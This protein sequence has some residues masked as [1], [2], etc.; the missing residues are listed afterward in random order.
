MEVFVT[1]ATGFLGSHLARFLI[2]RGSRVRR[3][4]RRPSHPGDI[5]WQ[6]ERGEIDATAFESADVVVH[7]AGEDIADGRW[8]SAKK[9]RIRDSRVK[10]TQLLSTT[11]ASLS[12]HPQLFVSASAVGY[13]GDRGEEVLTEESRSGAGFLAEVCR[14]WCF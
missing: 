5:G 11:L 8:T 2:Q 6:P 1:G 12:H 10:S 3:V 13:Y 4:T 14:Q 9:Q 7:L